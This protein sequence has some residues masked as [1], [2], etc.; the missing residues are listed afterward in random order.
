MPGTSVLAAVCLLGLPLI[1]QAK[2]HNNNKQ[3][4]SWQSVSGFLT[5]LGNNFAGRGQRV[6]ESQRS[7]QYQEPRAR[8]Y[9]QQNAWN[10]SREAAIQRALAGIGY[11][12]GPIDG[13]LGPM[14]RRAIANYQADRGLRVTGYPNDSLLRYLGLR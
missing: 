8:Y 11:Y 9:D 1:A 13:D 12:N 14:S 5:E 7:Y 4:V 10:N 2:D 3:S 6:V